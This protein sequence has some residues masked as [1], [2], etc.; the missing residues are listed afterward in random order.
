MDSHGWVKETKWHLAHVDAGV[1]FLHRVATF[2]TSGE[3]VQAS[4]AGD[5]YD[6]GSEEEAAQ[7]T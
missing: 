5:A 3:L 4:P 2:S 7:V 6:S 1:Y